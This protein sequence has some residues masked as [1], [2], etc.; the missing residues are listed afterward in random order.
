M[1]L[2]RNRDGSWNVMNREEY[3]QLSRH[4]DDYAHEIAIRLMGECG[5]RVSEVQNVRYN[6]IQ[7]TTD[8]QH[9]RLKLM[10]GVGSQEEPC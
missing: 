6:D 1:Q 10:Y 2:D 4:A 5:L 9:Y 3:E 7:R 8:G